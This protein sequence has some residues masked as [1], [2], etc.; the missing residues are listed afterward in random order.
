MWH[1]QRVGLSRK[2][3]QKDNSYNRL[4]IETTHVNLEMYDHTGNNWSH[5]NGNKNWEKLEAVPGIHSVGPKQTAILGKAH[6]IRK[7]LQ[8]EN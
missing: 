2:R 5:R 6:I 1:Y 3:E 7:V 4:C 8:C